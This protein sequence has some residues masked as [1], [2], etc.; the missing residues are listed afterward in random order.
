MPPLKPAPGDV[1]LLVRHGK[2]E[3]DH[4]LGDGARA[5]T[6][7]GRK[8]FRAHADSIA[9]RVRLQGIVTSPLVRAVQTA[10]ILAQASGVSEIAVRSELTAA[11]A[12]AA[13]IEVLARELGVGWALV[14][15][16]PSLG[17]ALAQMLRHSRS[18]VQFRKGAIVAI[19]PGVEGDPPWNL[20]WM[21]EPDRAVKRRIL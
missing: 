21:A 14:G 16:N 19:E 20:G 10:E 12:S 15:H 11:T 2:A 6:S 7:I 18:A 4:P 3:D 9:H 13:G 5:L 17:E 8:T 1:I